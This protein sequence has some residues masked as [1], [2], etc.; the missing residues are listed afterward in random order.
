MGPFCAGCNCTLT[1]DNREAL[2]TKFTQFTGGLTFFGFI[3]RFFTLLDVFQVAPVHHDNLVN[4]GW[5]KTTLVAGCDVGSVN[6]G[7]RHQG[8]GY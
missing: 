2:C 1:G 3:F 4:A 5:L 7:G 8:R 6:P